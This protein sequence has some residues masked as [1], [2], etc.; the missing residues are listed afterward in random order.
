MVCVV[1]SNVGLPT[2]K[3]PCS[4][5]DHTDRITLCI[6]R[7]IGTIPQITS[8][9]NDT[10]L[11]KLVGVAFPIVDPVGIRFEQLF[12]NLRKISL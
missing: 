7:H 10:A 8:L 4:Q 9:G 6:R 12:N 5:P 2:C 11:R 3:L 1:D